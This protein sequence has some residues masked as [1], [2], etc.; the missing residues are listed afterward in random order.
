MTN[1]SLVIQEFSSRMPDKSRRGR[2]HHALQTS[3]SAPRYPDDPPM[4]TGRLI[5]PAWDCSCGARCR[6]LRQAPTFER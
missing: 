3:L 5:V 2:A 4:L 1:T 6:D